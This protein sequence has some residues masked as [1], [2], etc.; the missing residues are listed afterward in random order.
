[1]STLPF[2]SLSLVRST[3][4]SVKAGD[5]LRITIAPRSSTSPDEVREVVVSKVVDGRVYTTSGKVR[6]G[7]ISGGAVLDYGTTIYFQSTMAQPIREVRTLVV[8]R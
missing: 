3:L 7:N 2:P 1:M 6:P 8:V 4:A 5:R